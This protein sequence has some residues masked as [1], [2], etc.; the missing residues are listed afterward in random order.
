MTVEPLLQP[1]SPPSRG[2]LRPCEPAVV[3]A[4]SRS[5]PGPCAGRRTSFPADSAAGER[6]P[7][8]ARPQCSPSRRSAESDRPHSR[9]APCHS[10]M[11]SISES[12]P[13]VQPVTTLKLRLPR[14]IE[15]IQVFLACHLANHSGTPV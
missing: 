5:L 1:R 13:F 4:N 7:E 14:F 15:K 11:G 9:W 10:C 12:E 2:H 6:T 3:P 8:L